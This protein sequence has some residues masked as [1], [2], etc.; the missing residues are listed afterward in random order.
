MYKLTCITLTCFF[1]LNAA[2]GS[3]PAP[4]DVVVNKVR[5]TISRTGTYNRYLERDKLSQNNLKRYVEKLGYDVT[6]VHHGGISCVPTQ[7]AKDLLTGGD[8]IIRPQGKMMTRHM[9]YSLYKNGD[10]FPL[11]IIFWSPQVRKSVH[12]SDNSEAVEVPVGS[13]IKY[14]NYFWP[15]L[16]TVHHDVHL[17]LD[18]DERKRKLSLTFTI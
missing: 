2:H 17:T 7:A 9:K 11:K 12:V 3:D 18:V 10:F 14:Q 5:I 8:L 1:V 4:D 16:F 13:I 15:D 6:D